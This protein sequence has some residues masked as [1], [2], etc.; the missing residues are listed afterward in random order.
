M[1]P[2]KV[3]QIFKLLL[4]I[5][6]IQFIGCEVEIT[7]NEEANPFLK[8]HTFEIDPLTTINYALI[9]PESYK[10][11][12]SYPALLAL[13]P[14]EQGMAQV[15]MA[16]NKY[17]IR[18][19]IQRN[20]IVISP[21]APG[22]IKYFNGSEIYIPMLCDAL[23]EVFNI[24]GGRFHIAGI[25]NGGVSAFRIGVIYSERIQSLTVFPGTPLS[26][27]TSLLNNIAD[28][29]ITMYWGAQEDPEL[30]TEMERT[31]QTLERLGADVNYR[32]WEN[33]GHI[34]DSLT[35][36]DLFDLLDGYRGL[37]KTRVKT[38]GVLAK[39][40]I[41]NIKLIGDPRRLLLSEK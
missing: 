6:S 34:I 29:P 33:E 31:I 19:S 10:S 25:S 12:E 41:L 15:N 28:I 24:E 36:E 23:E 26:Q 2:Y 5:F 27:D 39:N 16:I 20:W 1:F 17:Y 22:G 14:G 32:E 13:P 37:D 21:A 38:K 3:F 9:L 18:Q 35:P 4:L 8:Y 11:D 7:G 40:G 30:I